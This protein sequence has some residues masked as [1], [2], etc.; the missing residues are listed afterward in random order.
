MARLAIA[1]ARQQQAQAF[2]IPPPCA[3]P[4]AMGEGSGL[5]CQAPGGGEAMTGPLPP[6][7]DYMVN[8]QPTTTE[9]QP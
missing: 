7:P 2:Q 3:E 6:L 5:G 1:W 8:Y 4:V 9:D